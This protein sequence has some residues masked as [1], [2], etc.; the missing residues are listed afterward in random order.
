M[1]VT[2]DG[3]EV[4]FDLEGMTR[5]EIESRIA[6]TL[7]KTELVAKR[8]ELMQIAKLNPADFGSKCK[9]Q[10]TSLGTNAAKLQFIL[11]GLI[12]G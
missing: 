8:E 3:R 1:I 11:L 4:L 6:T 9:R 2:E 10:V 5:E 7:G 12:I